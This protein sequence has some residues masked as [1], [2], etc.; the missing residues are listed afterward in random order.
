M[1]RTAQ[2]VCEEQEKLLED[3]QAVMGGYLAARR[4]LRK[5]VHVLSKEDFDKAIDE[6]TEL[7]LQDVAAARFRLE[8]HIY[9]HQC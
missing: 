8:A 9:Q 7:M 3:Y 5:K 4:E 1:P 6:M 2:L